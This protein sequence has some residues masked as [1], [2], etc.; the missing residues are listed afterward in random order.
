MD[1]AQMPPGRTVS[2]LIEGQCVPQLFIPEL[3]ELHHRGRLPF[4]Q[5]VTMYPFEDINQAIADMQSGT[6]IKPIVVF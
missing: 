6:A 4:D 5:M 3:L 1:I 2:F